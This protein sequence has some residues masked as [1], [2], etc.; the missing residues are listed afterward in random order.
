[1]SIYVI[2]KVWDHSTAKGN[3]LLVLLALA[4]NADQE[5]SLAWPGVDLIAQKA[6]VDR[7][8][9]Q[10]CLR[11]L[12]EAG[13]I[14]LVRPGGRT[15]D[16]YRAAVYRVTPGGQGRQSDAPPAGATPEA[17]RGDKSDQ[18][19]VTPAPP[20]PLREP[21]TTDQG[22]PSDSVGSPSRPDDRA[23]IADLFGYWRERCGHPQAKMT[24]DRTAKVAARLRE[25]YTPEQIK[26]AIDG[27]QR[28]A[29]VNDDGKRFDDLELICRTGAKLESFIGRGNGAV[30]H[31]AASNASTGSTRL[32]NMA[33][34]LRGEPP[35]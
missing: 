7:R 14:V 21:S 11:R 33:A 13:E 22:S 17:S 16:G 10:R 30:R 19:G 1:M 9:A 18:V 28:G 27:A 12:E 8:T 29:F 25:G 26:A 6:R 23:I 34:E 31:S 15:T 5:R 35:A 4:D 20:Q 24:R 2:A 3:D 32:R